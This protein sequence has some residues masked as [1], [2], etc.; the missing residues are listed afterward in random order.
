MI[1]KHLILLLF[2]SLIPILLCGCAGTGERITEEPGINTNENIGIYEVSEFLDEERYDE[3]MNDAGS[4]FGRLQ[5]FRHQ[6]ANSSEFGFHAFA[7]NPVE[8][9]NRVIPEIC[10]VNHGT[11][12]E[13]ESRY[14]IDGES[15][16]A[17][18]AIQVSDRFFSLFPLK[19]TE[20]RGFEPSDFD[21]RNADTIPVI[22][23]DAYRDT[24]RPGDT[25]DGYYICDRRSF[26]VIGFT[27]TESDF[28]LRRGNRMAPYGRFIIMPFEKIGEDSFSVRAILLQ[29]ICGFI[30]TN[31][32]RESAL[33]TIREYLTENGLGNWCDAIAVSEKSLKEKL[34]QGTIPFDR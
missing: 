5:A 29:Q 30:V 4:L 16:T 12:Y 26:T 28:Y 25:F 23:G 34:N 3:Y 10:F 8:V 17:A 14:E 33:N 15:I 20:G 19:I 22:L 27:D 2:L 6:L 11:E 7:N 24:F 1:K 32:G 18:E 9:I 31:N 21:C 13:D